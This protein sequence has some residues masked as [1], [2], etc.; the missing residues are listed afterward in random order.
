MT[1]FLTRLAARSLGLVSVVEPLQPPMFAPESPLVAGGP[2]ATVVE[3]V[4][5]ESVEPGP[6]PRF[7]PVLAVRKGDEEGVPDKARTIA[8][9]RISLVA[10]ATTLPGETPPRP[11]DMQPEVFRR[12]LPGAAEPPAVLSPAINP[13][14]SQ[15]SSAPVQEEERQPAPSTV[16]TPAAQPHATDQPQGYDHRGSHVA[17]IPE[18]PTD[19]LTPEQG[20]TQGTPDTTPRAAGRRVAIERVLTPAVGVVLTPSVGV[21]PTSSAASVEFPADQRQA[22]LGP[23]PAAPTIRVSIGRIEVRAIMPPVPPV[24]PAPPAR[25]RPQLSLEDY[26]RQHRGGSQ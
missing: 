22:A 2:Q 23:V 21:V 14:T 18:I 16:M 5:L 7:R 9:P 4:G 8:P 19:V 13:R 3:E 17:P 26:L 1:D 6:S 12:E 24:R 10:P 25:P 11:V 20:S 15:P